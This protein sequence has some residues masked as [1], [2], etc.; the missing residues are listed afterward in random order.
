ML[1]CAV[2]G[3]TGYTG[4]ELIKILNGHSYAQVTA[5]TTRQKEVIPVQKLIPTFSTKS[6]LV[7]K[8]HSFA[9]LKQSC[10]VA[11]LCLPHT[12][13]MKTAEQLFRAGKYVID[14]SADLRLKDFKSYEKWYGVKHV[15]KSIIKDAVYGLSEIF[16]NE[17]KG[18]KL[19]ANPGCYPTGAILPIYPLLKE[20]L[21]DPTSIVIDA[22]S[23]MSGAG[24]KL[25][26]ST[27]FYDLQ[28]NFYAYKV[29]KHQH[30]PEIEQG[31]THAYGKKVHINFT[32]HLLP[33]KRGILSTIYLQAQPK[34]Q[35]RKI[36]R[37]LS[38]FYQNS[39][40]VRIKE[41]G[42]FPQLKDVQYTNYCDIGIHADRH[43]RVVL[44]SAID[45]LMKGASGQA[46]QN[47]NL[48]FGFPEDEGFK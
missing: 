46:V 22:K 32:T 4:I 47:M 16:P 31:L 6:N 38:E 34:V 35:D 29:G 2:V 5:L 40:F 17:I 9:E 14:L 26:E 48:C 12:E 33:V 45:N 10:D 37:T 3:A 20:K 13:A 24:K 36:H 39:P 8:E 44:V 18:A 27:Q 41:L 30:T 15:A 25:Q 43:G 23:G 42:E 1:K 11:F 19:I 28:E 7:V 21:I